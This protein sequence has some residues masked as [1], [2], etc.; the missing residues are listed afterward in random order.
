MYVDMVSHLCAIVTC[1]F[2]DIE[3]QKMSWPWNPGQRSLKII[4][5]ST[6]Q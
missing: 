1:R 2:S 6:I 5:S 3:L 4:E